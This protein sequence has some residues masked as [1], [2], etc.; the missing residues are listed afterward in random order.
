MATT[1]L[2]T[3]EEL[4][5]G[6]GPEGLWELID[7]ELVEM[8]ASGRAAG[9]LAMWIGTILLGFV[10]PRGLGEVY[11]A[12]TGFVL[13]PGRNVIRVPDA[14]FVRADRLQGLDDYNLIRLAPDLA[15]EVRSPNDC[16][17][18]VLAKIEMY[19]D[20]G[21]RLVWLVDPRART[22]ALHAP[23]REI[24]LLG[25]GDV[26]DGGEVLPG[27]RVDVAEVFRPL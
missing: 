11:G 21:V 5:R 9:K 25:E 2:W 23:G 6:G 20:A 12:D 18:D 27:F 7:G 4:D 15:V 13:F 26:L 17:P 14:S 1:K 19:L 24:R 22:I 10:L 16:V 8:T 3:V